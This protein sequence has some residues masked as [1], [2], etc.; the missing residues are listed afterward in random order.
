MI[1]TQPIVQ[2]PIPRY[3]PLSLIS[4]RLVELSVEF[5]QFI[6][7]TAPRKFDIRTL[8]SPLLLKAFQTEH[9]PASLDGHQKKPRD[10]LNAK[11]FVN[12]TEGVRHQI[13][14]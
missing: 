13:K 8:E 9:K 5:E 10:L 1:C 7:H 2:T 14:L 3:N 4:G 6:S 11:K 12:Q